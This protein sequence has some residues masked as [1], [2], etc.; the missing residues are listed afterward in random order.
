MPSF[1]NP[2]MIA[3]LHMTHSTEEPLADKQKDEHARNLN[4]RVR[5]LARSIENIEDPKLTETHAERFKSS[6]P[7]P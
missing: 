2:T 3:L 4:V 1:K 6:L 7:R 5:Q